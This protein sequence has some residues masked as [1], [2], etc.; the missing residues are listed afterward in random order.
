MTAELHHIGYVVDDLPAAAE[1]FARR[2]GAGPFYAL[3]HIVFDEVTYR[4]RPAAYDHSSA[5]G[6]WGPMMVELTEVHDAQ[7]AGLA[8]A[9]VKPGDGVGHAGFLADSLEDEVARLEGMGL[10]S[11]HAGQIG[12][13]SAVWFDGGPLLGHPIEVLQRRDELLGFYDMLRRE[14]DGWGGQDPYRP[15]TEPPA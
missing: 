5:F 3:E 12:P 15:M 1:R 7:P 10:V 14:S 4:G 2:Y 8:E 9:L 13:V 11:F 6:W